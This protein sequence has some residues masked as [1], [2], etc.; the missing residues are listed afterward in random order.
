M[1]GRLV[2][3]KKLCIFYLLLC[4][5]KTVSEAVGILLVQ[6]PKVVGMNR[7]DRILLDA[8]CSGTGVRIWQCV[9][10]IRLFE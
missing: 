6:L 9:R 10:W 5:G 4:E 3:A 7:V 8:P 2:K 1:D